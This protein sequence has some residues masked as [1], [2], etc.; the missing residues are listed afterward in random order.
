M[1]HNDSYRASR[2][3]VTNAL[4]TTRRRNSAQAPGVG[5]DVS[6][7]E[8]DAQLVDLWLRGPGSRHTRRAYASDAERFLR[9][10]NKPLCRV[11]VEDLQAFAESLTGARSSRRRTLSAIK[12]LLSFGQDTGY[13]QFNVGAAV[14]CPS[15]KDSLAE[16]ILSEEDVHRVI[17]TESAPRN[18]ALLRLLYAAGLRVSEACS[19]KWRDLQPR[20]EAGQV[21]VF[22][23]GDKTRTILLSEATW[24]ELA[25]LRGDAGPDDAVTGHDNR[26][27][28]AP[29]GV[30]YRPGAGT[31]QRG[32]F[33]VAARRTW[34]NLQQRIPDTALERSADQRKRQPETTVGVPEIG[35][36]L[37]RDSGCKGTRARLE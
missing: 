37:C 21:T 29:A 32:Q 8:N 28:V 6:G 33:P 35:A 25:A 4:T 11:S 10:V 24:A 14:K 30:A 19:L 26:Y 34:R 15:V 31:E 1:R 36:Q 27:R 2:E 20:D 22:G 18:R 3:T 17:V 5:G 12:S 16:R 13:L 23:K 9:F 7:A